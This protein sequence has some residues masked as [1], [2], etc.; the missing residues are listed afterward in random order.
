LLVTIFKLAQFITMGVF[1]VFISD[2]RKKTGMV[3]LVNEK[4]TMLL[5]L[6]YFVPV[7]ICAY[8][9]ATVDYLT[10]FDFVAL[11]L[12]FVGAV[13]VVKANVIW[14]SATLGQDTANNLQ[15]LKSAEY[16]RTCAILYTWECIC[17][18]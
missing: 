1:V 9:L 11:A 7:T 13:V 12:T 5:K 10:P 16:T 8:T 14:A 15:N 18:R 3:P 17:S 4:I 2:F 6:S